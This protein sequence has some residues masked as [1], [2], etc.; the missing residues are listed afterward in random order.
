MRIKRRKRRSTEKV[1]FL[2]DFARISKSLLFFFCTSSSS[3]IA[4]IFPRLPTFILITDFSIFLPFFFFFSISFF[5]PQMKA[6]ES[7]TLFLFLCFYINIS[8]FSSLQFPSSSLSCSH[9]PIWIRVLLYVLS[10]H[11]FALAA[12]L[13]ISFLFFFL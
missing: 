9:L 13:I 5:F 10:L 3:T 1:P 12:L 7:H 6:K 8:R 2:P 4:T 11:S